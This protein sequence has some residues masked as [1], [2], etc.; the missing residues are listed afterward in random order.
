ML[1]DRMFV[2]TK[3]FDRKWDELGCNDDDLAELQK[4]IS[5]NPQGHPVISGTGGIRK[6]R[7]ALQGRG[8]SGGAR[9]MYV[10]YV[11]HGTVG[12]LS[13]YPKSE[14]EI[15]TE[16]EKKVLK[17]ISEQISKNRRNEE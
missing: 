12:L 9:V 8:K 7:V 1:M 4:I 2:H 14:K 17:S 3:V 13:V 16:A 6:V 11:L 10:D 15:I 5:E